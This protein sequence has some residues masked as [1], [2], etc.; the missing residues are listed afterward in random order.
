MERKPGMLRRRIMSAGLATALFIGGVAGYKACTAP[1]ENLTQMQIN[2]L[3]VS[4]GYTA[5]GVEG[6]PCQMVQEQQG[7]YRAPT[8]ECVDE[9]GKVTS[10]AFRNGS[11]DAI[12]ANNYKIVRLA[13]ANAGKSKIV[14]GTKEIFSAIGKTMRDGYNNVRERLRD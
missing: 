1:P 5:V 3:P 14:E 13:E 11:L 4:P 7:K 9:S 2:A 8:I 12:A 10:Y 6:D